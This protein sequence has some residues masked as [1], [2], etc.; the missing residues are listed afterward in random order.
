MGRAYRKVSCVRER[1]HR[2]LILTLG[3]GFCIIFFISGCATMPLRHIPPST[4]RPDGIYHIVG[5]G[6]TLF[7]I[8]EAYNVDINDIML[9]N[10]IS[11]PN[12]LAVGEELFIPGAKTSI[13]VGPYLRPAPTTIEK[14]VLL[15]YPFSKWRYITIHHSAT[16]EGNAESFDRN[17]RSRRMGGLFY[18]F[19]IGNGTGS[20]NGEIE[21]GW[22]WR[23]Q[24]Y[25]NRPFDIQICLVGDFDRQRPREAQIDS[26]VRLLEILCLQ[27]NI[28]LD[29]I[30]RHKDIKDKV[31]ECP[32]E[33]FPFYRVLS[34]VNKYNAISTK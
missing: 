21:V 1:Q 6:Q 29:N 16:L 17:H 9:A 26:L 33:N 31:T 12:Q 13:P 22:R 18:H 8:A 3:G 28:S 19:V 27:Y 7:R 15:G 2:H 34:E 32:G 4:L 23:K 11:N 5:S 14:L 10:K 24:V 30:R 25:A 20:G